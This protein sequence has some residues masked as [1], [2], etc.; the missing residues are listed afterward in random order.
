MMR[1]TFAVILLL[2]LLAVAASPT[3]PVEA[4]SSRSASG[5]D[6]SARWNGFLAAVKSKDA[7]KVASFYSTDALLLDQGQPLLKGRA[8]IE[9]SMAKGLQGSLS[10]IVT[11]VLDTS[12]AGD[13]GYVV[14]SF[15][16]PTGTGGQQR[17]KIVMIWKR[18]GGEW[19]IAHDMFNTDGPASPAG[20]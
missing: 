4:Q 16:Q 8:A 11:T 3:A 5:Q 20:K 18:V 14:G 13:I 1:N 7:A 12:S 9:Q 15:T 10:Q 2:A 19:M 17:G 6:L